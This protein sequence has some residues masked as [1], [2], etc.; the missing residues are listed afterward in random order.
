VAAS[1]L[2]LRYLAR[3]EASTLL[4]LGTGQVAQQIAASHAATRPIRQ[5]GVHGRDRAK[6][7][8]LVERLD[9]QG[10]AAT[11]VDDLPQAVANADIVS[12]AT[13]SREPLIRGEWLRPG[14]HVD[15]IGGFTPQMRE[16]DDDAIR[17]ASVFIDTEGARHEAGDIVVPLR[18]GALPSSRILA[19]LADLVSAR[20]PGRTRPDEITLFKSVGA[21]S[22]DLAAAALAYERAL[23]S[24][25]SGSA[26]G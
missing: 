13:L 19:D 2:A 18:S 25:S 1:S 17:S 22:E 3:P 12:C 5:V 9:S 24:T 26:S 21:A 20:H 4:I 10:F 16:A 14:T 23:Q 7:A 6:V 11:A 15:L 8:A